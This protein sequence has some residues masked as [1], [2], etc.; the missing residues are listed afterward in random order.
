MTCPTDSQGSNQNCSMAP[1]VVLLG[2]G[3]PAGYEDFFEDV[4]E[5]FETIGIHAVAPFG[6]GGP[7][8]GSGY[9][10]GV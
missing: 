7:E 5:A 8:C 4:L 9:Y 10:P 1:L 6:N 3:A 2:F